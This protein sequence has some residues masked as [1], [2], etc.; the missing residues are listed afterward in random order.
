MGHRDSLTE[1]Q[2][3]MASCVKRR[4]FK[5]ANVGREPLMDEVGIVKTASQR[6]AR[7]KWSRTKDV[8]IH[9]YHAT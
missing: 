2:D 1:M 6:S 7:V 9:P 4:C 8:S 3:H 5:I